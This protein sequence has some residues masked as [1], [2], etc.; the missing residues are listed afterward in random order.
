MDIDDPTNTQTSELLDSQ[1]IEES[2]VLNFSESLLSTKKPA[3]LKGLLQ[4][5]HEQ[6][7]ELDQNVDKSSLESVT[8]ELVH[9]NIMKNKDK[10]V[11]ALAACCLA[12]IIRLHAPE[13]PY[14]IDVLRSIFI[15]F[16]DELSHFGKETAEFPYYFY[17]LENLQSV[18]TFLLLN[19]IDNVEEIVLPLIVEFFKVAQTGSLARNVELCMTDVL[20]Q[21]IDDVGISSP[22]FTEIILEQ[23]D[24]FEKGSKNSA[25]VMALDICYTCPGAL[26]RRVFQY[27]SDVL[28]SVSTAEESE[29]DYAEVKK[30]HNLICKINAVVPELLM[31]VLPLLQEEMKVDHINIRQLSTE[32][33]GRMFAEP[34][35]SVATQYPAIWKTWLGRRHDKSIQLRVKWLEMSVDIFKHHASAVSELIECYKDRLF[36]PD[37]RVRAATCRVIGE[38]SI[39][40]DIKNLDRRLLEM[41]SE[42]SKDK[43]TS[44]RVEAMKTFGSV[45]NHYYAQINA[46]D[47]TVMDKVGWIAD[48]LMYCLYLGNPA[49]TMNLESTLLTYILPENENDAERT[50]RLIVVVE[51]FAEKQKLAFTALIRKQKMFNDNLHK[52]IDMCE[53]AISSKGNLSEHEEAKNDEF[54]KYLA[55]QFAD[56]ART[57][58]A[59][60]TFLQSGNDKDVKA[61][62]TAVDLNRTYKQVLAA[63]KKLVSSLNEEHAA[64]LEIFQAILNRACP[65]IINK[66]NIPNLLKLSRTVRSRRQTVASQRATVAQDVLKE[67]STTHPSMY[68][69]NM[70][71][72]MKEILANNENSDEA[73]ELLAEVSKESNGKMKYSDE[74]SNCLINYMR[75]GDANQAHYASVAL[76]NMKNADVALAELV[77]RMCDEL[78]LKNHRLLSTL[79]SLSNFAL[80]AHDLVSTSLDS[81]IRFVESVLLVAKTKEFSSDNPEWEAYDDLPELSKQKLVGVR[82]LVNYLTACK[83]DVGPEEYIIQKIFGLLENLLDLSCDQAFSTKTNAAET[84]HLRLGASR[85][86]VKLTQHAKYVNQLTVPKF[87]KLGITLQDT[88]FYVRQEFAESLMKGL[89]TE[90]IHSRYYALL[91]MCAHEPEATLVKQVKGFIQKK[92]SSIQSKQGDANVLDSA[93]IRLVHLLAHHPDFSE[94][95]EDLEVLAQYFRFYL[96]CVATSD[97]VAFLYHIVQKIKLSTDTISAEMS[98]NSYILSDL[99]CL[100]IK[101]RCKEASWP[102]N[103]YAGRVSLPTRLYQLIPEGAVQSEI[104]NQTYLPAEFLEKYE[105]EQNHKA[106]DKR[107]R[108]ST[109]VSSKKVKA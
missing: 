69:S 12:D 77:S 73:L 84:S 49:V 60:R 97:N 54:M 103:A 16:V 28:I 85:A 42:R 88:C 94:A 74:L 83:E 109:T 76:S 101:T 7:K 82:L 13:S 29:D 63:K 47:K 95:V 66:S 26:Q 10:T 92:L 78:L 11:K 43:K 90:Q 44:V 18:K 53:K 33:L 25:Y 80:Y 55:G 48:R 58:N 32:T 34:S 19:D 2:P 6:L 20:I 104:M 79:T 36:D 3:E 35:S 98:K 71:D 87:E 50:E 57:L 41:I 31:N 62:K 9:K 59:L 5:L 107:S 64:I 96:A 105:E 24:K 27:F 102:L 51:S 89:H 45:Y 52:Y 38:V 40:Q 8:Q 91:F 99:A 86:L 70:A 30:A 93:L 56:K 37:E 100:L 23:F 68:T 4:N 72:I 67:I 108:F 39:G 14:S 21:L 65:L 17:L 75:E 61:L 22:E 1:M 106:G 15:F 81:V 46:H